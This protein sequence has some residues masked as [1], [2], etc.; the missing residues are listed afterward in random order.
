MFFLVLVAD[1]AAFALISEWFVCVGRIPH[2]R[3]CTRSEGKRDKSRVLRL[4][5]S[6]N[7]DVHKTTLTNMERYSGHDKLQWRLF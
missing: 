7:D 5:N 6:V 2:S 1:R 4:D 3:L